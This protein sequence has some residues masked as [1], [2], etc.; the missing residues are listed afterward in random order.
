MEF[1][2]SALSMR[3]LM[4]SSEK[5]DLKGCSSA[6]SASNVYFLIRRAPLLDGEEDP[7]RKTS[8]ARSARVYQLIV[9]AVASPVSWSRHPGLERLARRALGGRLAARA[10]GARSARQRSQIRFPCAPP[11]VA[12]P[13][14]RVAGRRQTRRPRRRSDPATS[15]PIRRCALR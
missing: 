8:D 9:A 6:P 10:P 11:D 13:Q 14:K 5:V 15:P 12:G 7:P 2:D 4:P 1:A 3:V